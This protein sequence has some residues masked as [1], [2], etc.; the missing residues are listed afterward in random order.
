MAMILSVTGSL[1]VDA[2][3]V[4]VGTRLFPSTKGYVHF[5]LSDYATLT[6]IGVV[7]A[8]AAWPVVTRVSWAPRWLFFRLA[9]V[10]TLVLWLPDIYLL[11]RHQ[12]VR[13]VAVL[14]VMH[15]L[16]ATVTYNILVRFAPAKQVSL[17]VPGSEDLKTHLSCVRERWFSRRALALHLTVA[18]LAPGCVA[19][20]WWQA[21]RALAGNELSWAYSVEWP[22]FALLAIAGWWH[23][24]HEDPEVYRARKQGPRGGEEVAVE[25]TQA[26]AATGLEGPEEVTVERSTARLATA[27]AVLI[28]VEFVLGIAA[29]ISVSAGRSSGWLPAKGETIYLVHSILGL[30]LALAAAV[31]LARVRRSER[32]YRLSGWI[33]AVGM[34]IAGAGGLLTVTHPLRILGI[35]FMLIGPVIASF[36][37]LIPSLERQPGDT[38]RAENR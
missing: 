20:G 2:L 3:L 4:F 19:A 32:T 11:V 6:I 13:A 30:P 29:L 21:T 31:F 34:A 23:L 22:V 7:I 28:G 24:I 26:R 15:L 25:D 1:A 16:I 17:L 8:C 27:L 12:P 33:G 18:I 37:Y 14:M 35:T 9:I 38:S 5:H 10:V 36:G